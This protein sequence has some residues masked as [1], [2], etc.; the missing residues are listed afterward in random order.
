MTMKNWQDTVINP[1]D[2][3]EKAITVLNDTGLQVCLVLND[4]QRLIGTVTDGDVRRGLLRSI[5]LRQSVREIMNDSPQVAHLDDD[6]AQ[7]CSLMTDLH[8]RVIPI[9][10]D[11]G[12][13][14]SIRTLDEFIAGEKGHEHWVLLMAGGLG[15][16]LRPMTRDIPKPMLPIG[17]KPLLETILENFIRQKFFRFYISVN[18]KAEMIRDYFEDGRKWGVE[19]RYLEEEGRLGTGGALRLISERPNKPMIVMNGDLLTQVNFQD[20]LHFHK[21]HG[22]SATMCVRSYE[23]QVPYGVVKTADSQIISIDE[24]PV[25][26][27]MVNAGIYILEPDLIDLIPQAGAHDMTML[28]DQALKDGHN[29]V[30]F[31]IREYWLDIGRKEDFNRANLEYHKVFTG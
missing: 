21:E 17:D 14:H 22:A 9:V 29:V 7:I 5:D 24:K 13:V 26:N 18:Y 15:S 10:D 30:A 31:P 23:T 1:A 3:I 4:R 27:F 6:E 25:H 12:T 28:F 20:L 11:D 16:R 2:S 8:L 19:I